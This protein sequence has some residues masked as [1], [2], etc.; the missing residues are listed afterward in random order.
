MFWKVR[1][2]PKFRDTWKLAIC[3]KGVTNMVAFWSE[4]GK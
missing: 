1:D 4:G 2:M 3:K